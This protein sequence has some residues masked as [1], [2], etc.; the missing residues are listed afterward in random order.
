MVK[1]HSTEEAIKKAAWKVFSRKG[2]EGT[3]MHDIADEAGVNKAMI[4]Y[5]FRSKE[6][7]FDIIFEQDLKRFIEGKIEIINKDVSLKEMIG[8]FITHDMDNMLHFPHLPIFI[9]N[10]ISRNPDLLLK[11]ISAVAKV[12]HFEKFARKVR[13]EIKE[14]KIIDISPEELMINMIA[15]VAFPFLSKPLNCHMMAMSEAAYGKLM[16][17]RKESVTRF[18]LKAIEK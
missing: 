14:G 17:K 10:E 7:L 5:Y 3:R 13:K 16:K 4:N 15:M 11:K 18:I 1:E 12:R 2:L 8:L 9:F 6:K